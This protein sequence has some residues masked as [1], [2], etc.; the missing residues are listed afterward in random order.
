MSLGFLYLSTS[1]HRIS[2][3]VV[4]VGVCSQPLQDRAA[5]SL[6]RQGPG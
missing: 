6:L 5:P 1:K 4:G 2:R 3:W